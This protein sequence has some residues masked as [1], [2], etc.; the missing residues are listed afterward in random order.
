MQ[1]RSEWAAPRPKHEHSDAKKRASAQL[2]LIGRRSAFFRA[3][4]GRETPA[5]SGHIF[6]ARRGALAMWPLALHITLQALRSLP[7]SYQTG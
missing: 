7:P 2:G 4:A 5:L 3:R 1:V 6:S